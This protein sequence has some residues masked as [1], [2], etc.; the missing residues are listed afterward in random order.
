MERSNTVKES[1]GD[2]RIIS[3]SRARL[4]ARTIRFPNY[5]LVAINNCTYYLLL[6]PPMLISVDAVLP[7]TQQC[8]QGKTK[9]STSIL[10][11][12]WKRKLISA[13]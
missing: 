7:Q 13:D 8:Q 9:L 2:R 4:F 10:T 12:G 3:E 11:S 5:R 6:Q 1:A